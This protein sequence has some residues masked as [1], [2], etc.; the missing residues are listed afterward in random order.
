MLSGRNWDRMY[1]TKAVDDRH[2]TPL[3]TVQPSSASFCAQTDIRLD[4]RH[5]R[6]DRCFIQ[7]GEKRSAR[8]RRRAIWCE[9]SSGKARVELGRRGRCCRSARKVEARYVCSFF[10]SVV[11]QDTANV[12][13]TPLPT[14]ISDRSSSA[15]LPSSPTSAWL[16]PN[17][18]WADR[19]S[20][21][22]Q[23]PRLR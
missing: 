18:N 22:R 14:K 8:R 13:D 17:E 16:P 5:E 7:S 1:G 21:S 10:S 20:S 12:K 19:S 2:P 9:G 4:F 23:W 6:V 15:C 3:T 11:D